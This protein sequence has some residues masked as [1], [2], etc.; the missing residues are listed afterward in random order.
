M[1]SWENTLTGTTSLPRG[2]NTGLQNRLVSEGHISRIACGPK[3][4]NRQGQ[5]EQRG[6]PG[7]VWSVCVKP[8]EEMGKAIQKWA[9]LVHF[10]SIMTI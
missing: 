7:G 6:W 5:T 1:N 4:D 2:P 8:S 9:V 10:G 3:S